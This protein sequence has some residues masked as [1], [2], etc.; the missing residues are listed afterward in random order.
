[1]KDWQSKKVIPELSKEQA[2]RMITD[3]PEQAADLLVV[4][5]KTV[6]VLSR[7]V[8]ELTSK[9]EDLEGR[10]SKNSSNSSKPPSSDGYKKP[11]PKSLRKKSGKKSGGQKGLKGTTLSSEERPQVFD[12]S[13]PRIAVVEHIAQTVKCSCGNIH[14]GTFPDG[15]TPPA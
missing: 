1:M 15:V 11:S 12:I 10:L 6:N 5:T 13:T 9:V 7:K 3:A 8:D 14:T 2:T 4:L